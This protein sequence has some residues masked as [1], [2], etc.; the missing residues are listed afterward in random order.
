MRS[1]ETDLTQDRLRQMLHYDPQTGIFTRLVRTSNRIKVGDIAGYKTEIG[2]IHISLDSFEHKAHRLAWLY[3][4]G[5]WPAGE[6][7]HKNEDKSDN[8]FDNLREAERIENMFNRGA[9]KDNVLGIKGVSLFK[10]TRVPRYRAAININ[11]KQKH[12]GLF[13]TVEEAATAYAEAAVKL[14]GKFLHSSVG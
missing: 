5:V 11:G 9:R 2:Y 14:H 13:A 12:L 4:A 6:V 1:E 8:R 3:M 10:G 7:D